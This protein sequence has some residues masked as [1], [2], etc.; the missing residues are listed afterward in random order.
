MNF[1]MY[2]V[3]K[4]KKLG[5]VKFGKLRRDGTLVVPNPWTLKWVFPYYFRLT[6]HQSMWILYLITT[7]F[8]LLGLIFVPYPI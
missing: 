3:W 5:D 6:E 7:F 1:L 2:I 8:G 4:I